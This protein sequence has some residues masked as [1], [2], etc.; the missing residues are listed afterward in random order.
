METPNSNTYNIYK[1]N[2]L[3]TIPQYIYKEMNA[4]KVSN[5]NKVFCDID[6]R[7]K[8]MNYQKPLVK[9][10]K[11]I[12]EANEIANT[13]IHIHEK[14]LKF[15]NLDYYHTKLFS[16]SIPPVKT[17][18]LELVKFK[19]NIV[20]EILRN[21]EF[22]DVIYDIFSNNK[23]CINSTKTCEKI[24]DYMEEGGGFNKDFN[25]FEIQYSICDNCIQDY[26][27]E[28]CKKQI[29]NKKYN[30]KTT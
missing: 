9:K 23:K 27:D 16:R 28:C 1:K 7:E 6:L 2:Y 11:Q 19:Q 8:I 14:I 29:T 24:E 22:I 30:R 26:F 15:E 20:S 4:N 17:R 12:E 21:P 10:I 18:K 13:F 3:K 5:F 25:G